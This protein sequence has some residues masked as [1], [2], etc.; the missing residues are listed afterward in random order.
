M[1]T[2]DDLVLA[3]MGAGRDP[4]GPVPDHVAEIGEL[5]GIGGRHGRIVFEIADDVDARRTEPGE[6]LAVLA[7]LDEADRDPR[8]QRPSGVGR[9]RPGLERTLRHP[10]VDEHQRDAPAVQRH[11]GVGPDLG[12]GDDGE[13]G[14][15]MREEALD[16]ARRVER[17]VLM[18]GAGGQALAQQVGGA[19]RA[20]GDENRAAAGDHALDQP[21]EGKRLA[22][23]R[24]VH[25]DE[26]AHRPRPAGKAA[27]LGQTDRILLAPARAPRQQPGHGGFAEIESVAVG[28][29]GDGELRDPH[30][31]LPCDAGADTPPTRSGRPTRV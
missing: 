8:Q 7:G 28:A 1:D 5:L 20:C 31:G 17:H 15:P 4:D 23:T 9:A 29:Q 12:F 25:P 18:H 13:I 27:A 16:P 22:D 3:G 24:P 6:A 26:M 14:L 11:D 30:A 10:A 2:G 19:A 21:D